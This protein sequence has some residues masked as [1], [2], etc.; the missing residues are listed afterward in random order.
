MPRSELNAQRSRHLV[1]VGPTASGKSALALTI[2]ARAGERCEIVSVDS[3]QVYRGMD[4][5]TAKPT[6]AERAQVRH[7]LID[8]VDPT[9][10]FSVARFQA[11]V[12]S[13]LADIECRGATAILV[14]GTGLYVRAIVDDLTIPGQWPAVRAELEI[15]A[16]VHGT[17]ALHARLAT[18]DP[19]AAHRME[20]TNR[21]RVIRALEVTIGSG[22][23][24]SSFGP[25]LEAYPPTPRFRQ[26]GLHVD[27]DELTARIDKRFR[28]MMADGLLDETRALLATYGEHLSATAR[29]ALGYRELLAHLQHGVPLDDAVDEAIRRTRTFAVRQER[30]FRRDPRIEFHP[31]DKLDALV[32]QVLGDWEEA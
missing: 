13:A 16:D 6:T 27:R 10:D 29:Q 32:D 8:V 19:D 4:I 14:G 23:P 22:R 17:P 20:P 18:L 12:R 26:I 3:M 24:F 30:W 2:A 11:A 31:A 5:G 28:Q 1:I 21:R 25:G 15:E 7:H 9:E